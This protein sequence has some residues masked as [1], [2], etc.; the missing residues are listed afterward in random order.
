MDS[1]INPRTLFTVY[2]LQPRLE[3]TVCS[4]LLV[5]YSVLSICDLPSVTRKGNQR[6]FLLLLCGTRFFILCENDQ[7][8]YSLLVKTGNSGMQWCLGLSFRRNSEPE[9]TWGTYLA[10]IVMG[11]A[12]GVQRETQVYLPLTL[13]RCGRFWRSGNGTVTP[14]KSP[15]DAS[16][17]TRSFPLPISLLWSNV[18]QLKVNTHHRQVL[19]FL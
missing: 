8:N 10:P 9:P 1:R 4:R 6:V 7:P 5:F 13:S 19:N 12:E 15:R 16:L 17:F 18:S 2:P 3:K 14:S 11:D